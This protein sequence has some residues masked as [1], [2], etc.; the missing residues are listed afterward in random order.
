MSVQIYPPLHSLSLSQIVTT[1]LQQLLAPLFKV[2]VQESW[3]T[4]FT[5]KQQISI[6]SVRRGQ[7]SPLPVVYY[8]LYLQK[9]SVSP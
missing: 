1:S 2:G 7:V 3:R 5:A 6:T 9:I 4:T 8:S